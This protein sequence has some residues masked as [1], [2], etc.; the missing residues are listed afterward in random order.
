MDNEAKRN[1]AIVVLIGLV[2]ALTAQGGS[3]QFLLK[4]VGAIFVLLIGAAMYQFYQR[5]ETSIQRMDLAPKLILIG[6][7]VAIEIVVF[8]GTVYPP[9]TPGGWAHGNLA[10]VFFMLLGLCAFG[11]WWGWNQRKGW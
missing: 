2:V 4:I 7:A 6:S 8:T 10:I 9:W 3:V 11:M 5:N 1:L